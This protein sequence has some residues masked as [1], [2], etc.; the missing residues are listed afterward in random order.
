MAQLVTL[1]PIALPTLKGEVVETVGEQL[2]SVGAGVVAGERRPRPFPLTIPLR[3]DRVAG[4]DRRTVGLRLRRQVRAL[5]ENP[6]ARMQ[7][8]YLNWAVDTEQNCWLLVGGGDVRPGPTGA[9]GIV[10]GDFELALTD[11]YRV[12]NQRTH[13]PARRVVMLDRRLVTTPRDYLRTVYATTFASTASQPRA[14]LP[15]AITDP[16]AGSTRRPLSLSTVTTADGSVTTYDATTDGEIVDFE[17]AEGDMNKADVKIWDRQGAG[18]VEASWERVYG[19]DQPL[20]SG[21]VPVIENALARAVWDATNTRW[22]VYS[23]VSGAWTLDATVNVGGV[24]AN[25]LASVRATVVEWTPERAVLRVTGVHTA[26]AQRAVIY[27]TLQRGWAGPRFEAYVSHISSTVGARIQVF[28]KSTG[29]ATFTKSSG[30]ALAITSGGSLGTMATFAAG[31]LLLGP[32]TDRA[33]WAAFHSETA[34]LQGAVLSSREGF[35]A[36][37]NNYVSVVVGMGV[38]A[39]GA[40]DAQTW[41]KIHMHQVDL[42]PELVA[43]A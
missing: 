22:D 27:V 29:D 31:A 1:G 11:C 14:W 20:T 43:R 33:V 26:D 35:S 16:V 10:F 13:R 41:G 17:Q 32:G 23:S 9:G 2:E 38:R 6:L 42:I 39:S 5:M 34:T 8:L 19:P 21:D 24:T 30:G 15:V 40:T 18:A 37:E 4:T 3:G 36:F 12:A 25:L 7:G 28:V